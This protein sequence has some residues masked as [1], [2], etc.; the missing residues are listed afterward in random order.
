MPNSCNIPFAPPIFFCS[1]LRD[2]LSSLGC[3]R[4]G[5]LGKSRSGEGLG[6]RFSSTKYRVL[7]NVQSD[8]GATINVNSA[9]S[10]FD[11]QLFSC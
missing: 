7:N 2:Q 4:S 3:R 8:G 11:F 10:P 6:L 9:G 1:G 5:S